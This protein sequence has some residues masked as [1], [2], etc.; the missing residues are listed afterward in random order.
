M[1]IKFFIFS[2]L[3]LSIG[4]LPL[5]EAHAF[6]VTAAKVAWGPLSK[7]AAVSSDEIKRLSQIIK[8]P[9]DV[10]KVKTTIGGMKLSPEAIED[11]YVRIAVHRGSIQ[12]AEAEAMFKNLHGVAG[13]GSTM[14]K[15]IGVNP[16]GTKG[17]LNELRI[18]NAA[19]ERG[20]KVD[21]IGIK[22]SDGIKKTD[23][24]LDILISKNGKKFPIEAKDYP[25]MTFNDLSNTMRPDMDS[26]VAFKKM[27]PMPENTH[28]IFTITN[29]PSDPNVLKMI[30]KDAERRGI[31][32]IFGSPE[33]QIIQIQQLQKIL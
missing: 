19:A 31:E 15:I 21:G 1:R 26:L 27:S 3:S 25:N 24:D 5:N 6:V 8:G 7:Q 23:T 17:H 11:T 16:A 14:S 33:Q 10:T 28:P 18:A 13:F 30:Q 2:F 20:Y 4:F 32:L 22:Y 9:G 12:R 29:R